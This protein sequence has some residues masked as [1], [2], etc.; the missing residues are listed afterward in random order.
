MLNIR[1]AKLFDTSQSIASAG[2]TPL[3][4]DTLSMSCHRLSSGQ[5]VFRGVL[6]SIQM[7]AA[8]FAFELSDFQAKASVDMPAGITT[9]GTWK[10]PVSNP[11][12][13]SIP[14][15]L[16]VQHLPELSE[17][18]AI[19]MLGE[20]PI[21]N[22]PAHVQVLNRNHVEPSHQIRC[23]LVQRVL[24][25]VGDL[26]VQSRHFQTLAIPAPTSF[27]ATGENPLQSCQPCGVAG[28]VARISNPLAVTQRGEPTDSQV[29]PD[30]ASSLGERGLGWF[31]QTKTH[32]V[33]SIPALGYRAG[34][35]LAR[36]T[37]TPL[38]VKPTNFGNCKVAVCRIP[39]ECS[40]SIRG[41]LLAVLAGELWI[42]RSLGEEIGECSLQMSQG[43]L[44]RDAGSFT[45]PSELWIGA[46]FRPS[47]A[48]G[49][50]VD[51]L[52]VLEAVRS[53]AQCEVVGVAHTAEL[54]RQLPRLAVCRV[55]PE[56]HANFHLQE[57]MFSCKICQ[58][59]ISTTEKAGLKPR[60]FQPIGSG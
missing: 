23:E 8:V 19:D 7:L 48:A 41:G 33:A 43:L 1:R 15:A 44:L 56:C 50:V 47:R 10:E 27:D 22:H 58:M 52:A 25:A 11:Q 28:S 26:G 46:M 42:G 37:A 20:L 17:A 6:I 45:Q 34:S 5:N 18:G 30:H 3:W 54:P 2:R 12:L 53:Q 60:G 40:C 49:I 36:E 38:D 35:W 4:T 14:S 16:V 31:I 57:S 39:F 21:L 59:L 51:R 9:L 29:N 24:A 13:A 55:A 32:E